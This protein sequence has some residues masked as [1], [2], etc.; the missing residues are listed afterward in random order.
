MM[1]P[2]Q[3]RGQE[4]PEELYNDFVHHQGHGFVLKSYTAVNSNVRYKDVSLGDSAYKCL[5]SPLEL[6]IHSIR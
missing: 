2:D 3:W 4:G 5:S 1:L 6:N